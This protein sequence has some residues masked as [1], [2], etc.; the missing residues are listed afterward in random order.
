M[1]FISSELQFSQAPVE[2]EP[3]ISI[4]ED[5]EEVEEDQEPGGQQAQPVADHSPPHHV[6]V[7]SC[8]GQWDSH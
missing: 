1:V 6:K 4:I 3:V 2:L 7:A 5:M 8:V